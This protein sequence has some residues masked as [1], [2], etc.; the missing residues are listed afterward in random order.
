MIDIFPMVCLDLAQS[1]R[2]YEG[3]LPMRHRPLR[4]WLQWLED[5]LRTL[6]S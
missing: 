5:W 1:R 2:E 6:R 3:A 4:H